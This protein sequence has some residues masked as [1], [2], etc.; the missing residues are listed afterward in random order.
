MLSPPD[1]PVSKHQPDSVKTL[2]FNSRSPLRQPI[3]PAMNNIMIILCYTV[4]H[5][6][7]G[8]FGLAGREDAVWRTFL[9]GLQR[10]EIE[11]RLL[12]S[13]QSAGDNFRW[14]K[15]FQRDLQERIVAYYDGEPVDFSTDPP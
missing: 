8:Y 12:E 14:N 2:F 15:D 3:L 13:A 7:W 4:F 10:Q 9:P 1:L 6:R 5:T 11:Q